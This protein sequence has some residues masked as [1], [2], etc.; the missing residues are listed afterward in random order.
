MKCPFCQN[1]MGDAAD[2]CPRCH[3][4]HAPQVAQY[5][6]QGWNALHAGAEEQAR[7]ALESGAYAIVVGTAITAPNAIT[8][9]FVQALQHVAPRQS[10]SGR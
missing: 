5:I 9:R 3:R 2:A 7:A 4:R 10:G 8:A 6:T 1:E